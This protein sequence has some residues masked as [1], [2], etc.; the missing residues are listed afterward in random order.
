VAIGSFAAA[1]E[2]KKATSDEGCS[3]VNWP[4][5]RPQSEWR[6]RAFGLAAV[7]VGLMWLSS[8]IENRPRGQSINVQLHRSLPLGVITR[9]RAEI[10]TLPE[11]EVSNVGRAMLP[12]EKQSK[13]IV[14][15]QANG[16]RSRTLL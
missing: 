8:A 12:N 16:R 5:E 4:G 6:K 3:S 13:N 2:E 11:F 1:I 7:V 9:C 14:G 15:P 10:S